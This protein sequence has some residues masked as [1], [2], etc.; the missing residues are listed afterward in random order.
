[1]FALSLGGHPGRKAKSRAELAVCLQGQEPGL[2]E[3]TETQR[4]GIAHRRLLNFDI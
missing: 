2:R 4:P 1:M 3:G